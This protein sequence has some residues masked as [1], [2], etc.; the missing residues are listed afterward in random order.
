MKLIASIMLA[1]LSSCSAYPALAHSW[2]DHECCHDQDCGPILRVEKVAS[3][4]NFGGAPTDPQLP[5][6]ILITSHGRG[7][8]TEKTKIK[9][10]KDSASHACVVAGHIRCWYQAPGN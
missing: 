1:A 9:E 10:S 7:Q 8:V 5:V 3:W 2:Y 4:S 6:I